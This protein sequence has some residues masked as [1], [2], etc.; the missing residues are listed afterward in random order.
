MSKEDFSTEEA[1]GSFILLLPA[2]TFLK[3]AEVLSAC[4]RQAWLFWISD[5]GEGLCDSQRAQE[6]G[7][8][9]SPIWRAAELGQGICATTTPT[10]TPQQHMGMRGSALWGSP[11]SGPCAPVAGACI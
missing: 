2:D 3:S 11:H 9:L 8:P 4:F 1:E 5:N 7:R 6:A 10:H